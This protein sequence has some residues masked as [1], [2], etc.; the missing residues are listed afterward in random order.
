MLGRPYVGSTLCWV[1]LMLGRPYVGLTLC[2]VDLMLG[3]PYVGLTL[4]QV[5]LI[6]GHPHVRLTSCGVDLMSGYLTSG[7]PYVGSTFCQVDILSGRH[8]VRSTFCHSTSKVD[9]RYS[10]LVVFAVPWLFRRSWVG[11]IKLFREVIYTKLFY[12]SQ[13]VAARNLLL[14][15]IFAGKSRS[16]QL[17]ELQFYSQMLC[18]VSWHDMLKSFTVEAALNKLIGVASISQISFSDQIHFSRSAPFQ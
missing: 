10:N 1:D 7:R 12:G 18:K 17:G 16:I 9:H 4:H 15:L 3:R 2:W 8:F 5:D 6:S 14:G 13:I 11:N